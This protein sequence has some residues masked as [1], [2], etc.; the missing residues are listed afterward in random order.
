MDYIEATSKSTNGAKATKTIKKIA[1]QLGRA[2]NMLITPS[3]KQEVLKRLFL[4]LKIHQK[5]I[6]EALEVKE[7]TLLSNLLKLIATSNNIQRR[8]LLTLL[9]GCK[10]TW[11]EL[12]Q[13]T[14]QIISEQNEET[15]DQMRG[16]PSVQVYTD[17][18][19]S[20]I[21]YFG[22]EKYTRERFLITKQS[23]YETISLFFSLNSHPSTYT[24]KDLDELFI[25]HFENESA[26]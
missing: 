13:A 1:H 15:K 26:L 7:T 8:N 6:K 9:K 5:E 18:M 21:D 22:Y 10:F 25:L 19:N 11:K 16:F 24:N 23:L 12:D 3:N 17:V 14:V 2:V 20:S 4:N